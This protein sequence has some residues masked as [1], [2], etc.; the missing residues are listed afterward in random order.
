MFQVIEV[1][2]GD[3]FKV[4][5]NWEW[6]GKTG[7]TVRPLG[8][9]TPEIGEP[10]HEQMTQELSELILGKNVELKNVVN[11]TYGRILCDVYIGGNNLA[12]YFSQYQ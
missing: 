4:S 9:D 5:P 7:D 11:M 12:S 8:Y 10:E 2:D 1:I 6:D 3:T